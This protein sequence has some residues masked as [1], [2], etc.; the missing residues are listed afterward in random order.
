MRKLFF[1]N[2][3]HSSDIPSNLQ[4]TGSHIFSQLSNEEPAK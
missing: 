4:M 3:K 1:T 2:L